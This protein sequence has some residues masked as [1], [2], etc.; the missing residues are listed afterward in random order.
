M[1][2]SIFFVI[3]LKLD[4]SSQG[5]IPFSAYIKELTDNLIAN[6]RA[7]PSLIGES[8]SSELSETSKEFIDKHFEQYERLVLTSQQKEFY[9]SKRSLGTGSGEDDGSERE[10]RVTELLPFTNIS[11]LPSKD[12]RFFQQ[13]SQWYL[14]S[15]ETTNLI[16]DVMRIMRY[17]NGTVTSI[18][19]V[20]IHNGERVATFNLGNTTLIIVAENSR[21][22]NQATNIYQFDLNEDL[23]RIQQLQGA[24]YTD[25]T[26]WEDNT[27]VFMSLVGFMGSSAVSTSSI[28]RLYKWHGRHFDNLQDIRYGATRISPFSIGDSAFIGVAYAISED[29]GIE[30]RRLTK[31]S[32]V[33]K[34]ME[35]YFYPFQSIYQNGVLQWEPVQ[36]IHGNSLL[37]ALTTNGIK[38]FQYD[39][40]NF[41]ETS[42]KFKED[43]A[44]KKMLNFQ[45]IHGFKVAEKN[46]LVAASTTENENKIFE[47]RISTRNEVKEIHDQLLNWCEEKI[48]AFDERDSNVLGD[49]RE[50]NVPETASQTKNT[51]LNDLITK[52]KE[53]RSKLSVI[54]QQLEDSL[55]SPGHHTLDYDI[56]AKTIF[57]KSTVESD[58]IT[59]DSIN[60]IDINKLLD[61]KL[62]ISEDF[63]LDS[64][65]MLD[66]VRFE[67]TVVPVMFNN[68][69]T[70]SIVYKNLNQ[71]LKNLVING[72]VT[73]KD[74]IEIKNTLNNIKIRQ[75]T[76]LLKNADQSFDNLRA[77][78]VSADRIHAKA[79]NGR[80][81]DKI[82]VPETTTAEVDTTIL[83]EPTTTIPTTTALPKNTVKKM[84]TL[85]AKN[86]IVDGLING[87]DMATLEKYALKKFGKQNITG[88][89]FFDKI[90]TEQLNTKWLT[91]SKIPDALITT[92]SPTIELGK[93]VFTQKLKVKDLLV[94]R[95]LNGLQVNRGGELQV[96]YKNSS[97]HQ[98]INGEKTFDNLVLLSPPDLRG[99]K[100]GKAFD[101]F[102]NVLNVTKDLTLN[103]TITLSGPVDVERQ[104]KSKDIIYRKGDINKKI[105]LPEVSRKEL[106]ENVITENTTSLDLKST[107]KKD[108]KMLE[109]AK[110]HKAGGTHQ[111]NNDQKLESLL[112]VLQQGIKLTDDKI[113]A[114]IDL[115]VPLNVVEVEADHINSVNTHTFIV[116]GSSKTVEIKGWNTF[117]GDLT[118][119][120]DTHIMDIN[121]VKAQDLE[122]NV[123]TVH[124][125]QIVKGKHLIKHVII[126]KSLKVN[127][128]I[129]LGKHSWDHVVTVGGNQTIE[130]TLTVQDLTA[131]SVSLKNLHTHG[132]INSL[133]VSAMLKDLVPIDGNVKVLG[134]KTFETINITHLLLD[135]KFDVNQHISALRTKKLVVNNVDN[136]D[137][138]TAEKVYFGESC[139]GLSKEKFQNATESENGT[140]NVNDED[141]F[142]TITVLGTVFVNN[143]QI[144]HVDIDDFEENTV[145]IDEPFKFNNADFGKQVVVLPAVTI[146]GQIEDLDL[147][148]IFEN[149]KKESQTLSDKITF[150]N[151]VL[152]N[153]TANIK[154]SLNEVNMTDLCG[155]L[156]TVE[157]PKDLVIE[158][159][160][161]F[162]KGPKIQEFNG[163]DAR[164]L[165]RTIWFT[166]TAAALT[167]HLSL[168][169]NVTAR[170][171]ITVGGLL[172]DINLQHIAGNYLSK[173]QDQKIVARINIANTTIFRTELLTSN[174]V[175]KGLIN[176]IKLDQFLKTRLL[177]KSQLFEEL[178]YFEE[179]TANQLEGNYLVN[180]LNLQTDVMRYDRSNVITGTK[181]FRNLDVDVL[182]PERKAAAAT[183]TPVSRV[184]DVDIGQWMETVVLKTGTY[185][186]NGRKK[187]RVIETKES[188]SLIGTFN[189]ETLDRHTIMMRNTDQNITGIKI[190]TPSK[191]EE[192]YFKGLKV[193]GLVNGEDF[194]KLIHNQAYK[195]AENVFNTS[196]EFCNNITARNVIFG[197]K[198]SNIDVSELLNNI[199][200][201]GTLNHI[202]EK[203]KSL[204]NMTEQVETSLKGQ[205]YFL[206]YYKP[207]LLSFDIAALT[208]LTCTTGEQ[209]IVS[210][211]NESG[212][213]IVKF[214]EW[215]EKL[216]MFVNA[217]VDTNMGIYPNYIN[218]FFFDNSD[219]IYLEQKI[220]K[221]RE[222][223]THVGK[224]M[225]CRN[226]TVFTAGE[227]S[228]RGTIVDMSFQMKAQESW[229]L[230]FVDFSFD[231]NILCVG[232]DKQFRQ[233]QIIKNKSPVLASVAQTN[234]HLFL[235]TVHKNVENK[236]S[237]WKLNKDN[238]FEVFQTFHDG[239]PISVSTLAVD[240]DI[241]VAIAYEH[242]PKTKDFGKVILRRF[243]NTLNS[244]QLFQTIHIPL[245]TKVQL[246]LLPSKE[247]VLYVVT[248]NLSE[249]LAGYLYNGVE[250]FKKKI[251]S[252][253]IPKV[254]DIRTFSY[255]NQHFVVMKHAKDVSVLQGVF[256]GTKIDN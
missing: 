104:L 136:L 124:T 47:I 85:K 2:I 244:F 163:K 223:V 189:G 123:L 87:L 139:N 71:S 64:E 172:N 166:D 147:D 170:D 91:N 232:K 228:T 90:V 171:S 242:L 88:Q 125:D 68:H 234:D 207:V 70:D 151:V 238:Q 17:Q 213:S 253:A 132:K 161:H 10:D 183:K 131:T 57:S 159:N 80:Q 177:H 66:I 173:T 105:D 56:S 6:L 187:F 247:I 185:K 30:H 245:P 1:L 39:G 73:F 16:S 181:T 98:Q 192:I 145:K 233:N 178:V 249:P 84:K 217:S 252:P 218:E 227:F 254:K 156:S 251:G 52:L 65:I 23:H 54:E 169:G 95:N 43:A 126:N 50:D 184:Q 133:N 117:E 101:R 14:V 27:N 100:M 222:D 48:A 142:D 5:V 194:E 160:V 146:H 165:D 112:R 174:V 33:Y 4:F 248:E 60:K 74:D 15:L 31:P 102:N 77:S 79:M 224:F 206:D 89:F 58:E 83:D 204:Q 69:P 44:E 61:N 45:T 32:I 94:T 106:T 92:N 154:D 198:Y 153:G 110:S 179:V 143:N 157:E 76:I 34:Y 78:A 203:Y 212:I 82:D 256:K 158:G 49:V 63:V 221:P 138:V 196:L 240:Q 140:I 25:V 209:R 197:K 128:T 28:S 155:I 107:Q 122:N 168:N 72:T 67:S 62:D 235:V 9:R 216:E 137:I 225:T 220:P 211:R 103:K 19:E 201:L 36:E 188:T 246:S 167:G 236:T 149:G 24:G 121:G 176:N 141:E 191:N 20:K 42:I 75:D 35:N 8:S 202:K 195:N 81:I 175:V 115:R 118:L 116:Q 99:K 12:I 199:T 3:F 190:F 120:G 255:R 193:K 250:G 129:K 111:V 210:F 38:S 113:D 96:L 182:R 97:E 134:T 200:T 114:T 119:V 162:V 148:N 243:D 239:N 21:G 41:V 214:L 93:A 109:N 59:V 208:P 18:K 135:N 29:D 46:V 7:D 11:L 229:C 152:I 237:V 241:F 40:W 130:G 53:Q 51:D 226:G 215:D 150:D 86:L 26:I 144:N 231:I 230:L 205:A 186:I 22:A 37:L 13:N 127:D 164:E 108:L 55:Q 180:K 219:K